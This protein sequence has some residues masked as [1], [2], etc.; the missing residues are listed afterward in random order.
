[1]KGREVRR[2]RGL[3]RLYYWK[4]RKRSTGTRRRDL[5]GKRRRRRE[6]NAEDRREEIWS[7]N[8]NE[9]ELTAW[10]SQNNAG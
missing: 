1:M 7:R 4:R 5:E 6:R 8:G 2:K 9:Q 3:E 10:C